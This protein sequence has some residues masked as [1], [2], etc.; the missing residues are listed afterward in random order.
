[1]LTFLDD[2]LDNLLQ[3]HTAQEDASAFL[4]APAVLVGLF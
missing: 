3:H 1:L 4:A 2:R